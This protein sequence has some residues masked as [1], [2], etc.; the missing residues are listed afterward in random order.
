MA[1]DSVW[2]RLFRLWALYGSMDLLWLARGPRIAVPFILSDFVTG[3]ATITATFLL[4]ERFN[5]IGPWAK[6]Q[7]L[8]LLGYSLLVR[9]LIDVLFNFNMAQVSRRIGRGQLD[10]LLI[11]PQPLWMA[12]LTEGFAPFSGAG[13]LLPG[14][15]LTVYSVAELQLSVSGTWVALF[16]L[17]LVGSIAIVLSFEYAW[18]S[19]AFW[20]P[21]AA[22]EINSDTWRLIT[23]LAPFPL[24]GIAGWALAGLLTILPVG[25]VAWYPA[26]VLLR[27]AGPPWAPLV[28]PV[29]ALIASAFATW[30][31]TRGLNQYGRTGSSRYLSL[32]H[33]R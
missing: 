16:A 29:A 1:A 30:I 11:Q 19:V 20:A 9:G 24:E 6:P 26:R 7:V 21:R 3:I 10:H 2:R 15:G 31:F 23:Q 8:F 33:R 13:M 5:G 28:L 17:Y 27:M 14:L 22:E 18:A 25:L 4:A 12:F 32:G